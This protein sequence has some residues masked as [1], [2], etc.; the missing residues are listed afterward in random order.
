[1]KVKVNTGNILSISNKDWIQVIR[2]VSLLAKNYCEVQILESGLVLKIEFKGQAK[3]LETADISQ[4]FGQTGN[5][6]EVILYKGADIEVRI[7]EH[8]SEVE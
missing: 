7:G 6:P 3:G 5:P 4:R 8:D 2:K 1:M